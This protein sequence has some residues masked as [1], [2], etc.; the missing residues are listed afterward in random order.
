MTGVTTTFEIGRIAEI[1]KDNATHGT[2]ARQWLC[3]AAMSS[4][5][6]KADIEVFDSKADAELRAADVLGT[7]VAGPQYN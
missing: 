6:K 4:D 5:R 1:D 2:R 3:I 7:G